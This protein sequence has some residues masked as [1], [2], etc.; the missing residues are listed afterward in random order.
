MGGFGAA[1]VAF[2]SGGLEGTRLDFRA[3]I[4]HVPT[5]CRRKG[6]GDIPQV[7][8]NKPAELKHRTTDLAL[9]CL[10]PMDSSFRFDCF[11]LL[12]SCELIP[13]LPCS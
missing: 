4:L 3:Q 8:G 1:E 11:H 7:D 9:S 13:L 5:F 6:L 2:L 12:G 10:H